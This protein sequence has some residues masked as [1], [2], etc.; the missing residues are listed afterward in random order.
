MPDGMSS[1]RFFRI[2]GELK[3][4]GDKSLAHRYLFFAPFAE[5]PLKLFNLPAGLDVCSS[6]ECLRKCGVKIE[7]DAPVV[8][9]NPFSPDISGRKSGGPVQLNCGNSGTTARFLMGFLSAVKISAEI[10]GDDSLNKRPMMRAAEPLIKM[11][12]VIPLSENGTLPAVIG[13]TKKLSGISWEMR[14]P[15]AQVKTAILLAGLKADGT[16]VIKE[17]TKTRDHTE[18]VLEK[19]GADIRR[20]NNETTLTPLKKPMQFPEEITIPGDIS[21]T[22]FYITAACILGGSHLLI[23]NVLL[24]SHRAHYL[25]VL[26]RM[27]ACLEI[28]DEDE[29]FGERTGTIEVH[30]RNLLKGTDISGEETVMCIDEIP[31]LAVAASF[32]NGKSVFRDLRELRLKESDRLYAL[33]YNLKKL[34]VDARVESDSLIIN[35]KSC[36]VSLFPD[37]KRSNEDLK[38]ECGST[39]INVMRE[40]D[41]FGDHRIAMAMSVASLA[42]RKRLSIKG[43]ECEAV[44]APQFHKDLEKL[45]VERRKTNVFLS[46]YMG[47]GKTTVG[48]LLAE[49]MHYEFIDLDERIRSAAGK[50]IWKIFSEDGEN[51]FRELEKQELKNLDGQKNIVAALGG[52]TTCNPE[53]SEFIYKNGLMVLLTAPVENLFERIQDEKSRPLAKDYNVFQELFGK[54]LDSGCYSFAD[55]VCSTEN[56]A[57]EEIAEA[58]SQFFLH[59]FE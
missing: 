6:I 20:N 47:A 35:G 49:K 25:Q 30:F 50:P 52:G 17:M 41:S 2:N 7:G 57:P 1:L 58:L 28:R 59:F 43:I 26:N 34:G 45:L 10:S 29:S 44:S 32:A 38:T 15:S 51:S 42:V 24:N 5:K 21:T 19:A 48:R 23:K 12:A 16:T 4:P 27:G 55:I 31:A 13:E 54:R 56:A 33:E 9:I 36:T 11:G 40:L 37:N 3:L 8:R 22:A 53:N 39:G 18:I 14:I 46:G